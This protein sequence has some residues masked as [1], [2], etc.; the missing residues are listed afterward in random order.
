MP[1]PTDDGERQFLDIIERHGW[2]VMFVLGNDEGPGF[3]YSSGI[4]KLTGKPEVIVF[5]LP[6]QVAHFVINDYAERAKAGQT[7]EAGG[8]YD[9]FLEGHPVTFVAADAPDRDREYTTWASWFYDRQSFPVLQMVY[10]DT[11]SGAFPWQPGYREEWREL[12]PLLGNPVI[13]N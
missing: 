8:F 13:L 10:P 12:Q 11:R 2:H 6:R 1:A 5:S 3:A 7:L 9:E 4:Y